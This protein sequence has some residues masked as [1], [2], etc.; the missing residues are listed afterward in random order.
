LVNASLQISAKSFNSPIDIHVLL[1]LHWH[2]E[3]LPSI[4]YT[5]TM[6]SPTPKKFFL[7]T[8]P[9]TSSNLLTNILSLEDQPSII[10]QSK[11]ELFFAPTMKWKL[12]PAQ[13]GA[14]P[15]A[16]WT[17]E[18]KEGLKDSLQS[19]ANAL[20]NVLTRAEEE[21]RYVYIKEHV[22]FML[23]PVGESSWAYGPKGDSAVPWTVDIAG[24]S[25][26][27]HSPGNP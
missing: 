20:G 26:R 21:G 12:G 9:R 5:H 22:N 27:K 17:D 25:E 6:T 18:Q 23:E 14:K 2:F 4:S 8:T 1:P 11:R 15:L 19:C 7:L 13:L 24:L 3:L 10:P 16:E